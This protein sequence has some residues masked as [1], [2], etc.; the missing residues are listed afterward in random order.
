LDGGIAQRLDLDTGLELRAGRT[1]AGDDRLRV[2][3]GLGARVR[4][5][6]RLGRRRRLGTSREQY[7]QRGGDD[8]YKATLVHVGEVR[9]SGSPRSIRAARWHV[10]IMPPRL[11]PLQFRYRHHKQSENLTRVR[12][13]RASVPRAE[14][15]LQLVPDAAVAVRRR[16]PGH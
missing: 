1:D 2:R 15:R 9:D 4:L 5:H 10:R 13:T 12:E 3:V 7:T 6:G 8:V 11:W 14:R 16:V